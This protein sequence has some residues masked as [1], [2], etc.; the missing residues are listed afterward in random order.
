MKSVTIT[1]EDCSISVTDNV[2]DPE[3]IIKTMQETLLGLG[4]PSEVLFKYFE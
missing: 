1:N 3:I 2:G 4:Y